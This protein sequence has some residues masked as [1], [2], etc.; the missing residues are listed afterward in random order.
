[1]L[2]AVTA[3]GCAHTRCAIMRIAYIVNAVITFKRVYTI[4]ADACVCRMFYRRNM[5]TRS[6]CMVYMHAPQS[7]NKPY[8]CVQTCTRCT[9]NTHIA[10]WLRMWMRCPHH[11][12][13]IEQTT[14]QQLVPPTTSS[15][16]TSSHLTDVLT[17]NSGA[18][19]W[20][21]IFC[22]LIESCDLIVEFDH[23]CYTTYIM[24]LYRGIE[25]NMHIS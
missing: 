19:N 1:M 20:A 14:I 9:Y 17:R 23:W 11:T 25:Y 5:R 12:Q 8:S 24:L 15:S 10:R 21:R 16:S 4:H 18:H 13:N 6:A 22:V 3:D 7:N 2:D